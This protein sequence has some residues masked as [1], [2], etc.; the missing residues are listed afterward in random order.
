M[1]LVVVKKD[2]ES[3]DKDSFMPKFSSEGLSIVA[4]LWA[5]LDLEIQFLK[6]SFIILPKGQWF[7]FRKDK[8]Q[9]YFVVKKLGF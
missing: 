6:R 9:G 8:L 7:F 3:G 2:R 4:A 5:K 1:R